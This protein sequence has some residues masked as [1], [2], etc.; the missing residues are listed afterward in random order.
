MVVG[1]TYENNLYLINLSAHAREGYSSRPV[2][3]ALILEITDN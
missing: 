3:H 1:W 2:C